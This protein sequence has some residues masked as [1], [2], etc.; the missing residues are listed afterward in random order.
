MQFT[1][2]FYS[3]PPGGLAQ[4]RRPLAGVFIL[5]APEVPPPLRP[6]RTPISRR[7]ATS[8]DPPPPCRSLTRRRVDGRRRSPPRYHDGQ[9][10]RGITSRVFPAVTKSTLRLFQ[11]IPSFW[12]GN[13][14]PP[15][16]LSRPL[17]PVDQS[18]TQTCCGVPPRCRRC[19]CGMRRIPQ[20]PVVASSEPRARPSLVGV[21]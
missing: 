4:A 6:W 9:G 11:R 15:T 1:Q 16:A 7:G 18:P 19:S 2:V 14:L 20:A 5:G 13:Q 21:M 3:P 8:I 10:R 17:P 12:D